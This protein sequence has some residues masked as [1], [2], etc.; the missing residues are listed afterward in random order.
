MAGAP[1][2]NKNAAKT[3]EW[4]AAIYRALEKRGLGDRKVAMDDLAEKLLQKCSEA[5]LAALREFGDRM[6]GKPAQAI[7]G[8]TEDDPAIKALLEVVFKSAGQ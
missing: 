1:L 5:D 6:D 4:Q 8:G 2:G 7:I 3:K